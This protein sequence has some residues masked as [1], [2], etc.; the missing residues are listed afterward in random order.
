MQSFSGY[1]ILIVQGAQ[2]LNKV[3]GLDKEEY[4]K[5]NLSID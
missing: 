5:E 4:K 2:L 1:P 3:K